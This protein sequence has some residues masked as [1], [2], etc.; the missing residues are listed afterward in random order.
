MH[1]YGRHTSYNVQKVLWLADELSV[2]YQ[3]T[4]VGGAYGGI[5]APSFIEMNPLGK[6]PV[7]DADGKYIW[8]SNTIVRYLASEF[9]TGHWASGDAYTESLKNRWLDWS[10]EKLDA[11]FVG[12]FWGYYRTPEKQRDNGAIKQSVLDCNSCLTI[13]ADQLD[14]QSFLLGEEISIADICTAVYLHRLYAIDLDIEFPDPVL[15]WYNRLSKRPAYLKWAMSDFTMLKD[16]T[17]N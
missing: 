4:E 17:I 10:I 6:V 7:L 5:D 1:I 9:G 12:V 2:S 11:A 15:A 3:H 14:D 16:R 13:L 8:E